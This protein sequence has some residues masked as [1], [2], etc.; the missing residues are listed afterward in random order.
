LSLVELSSS[1][2]IAAGA[3]F[4]CLETKE[5]KI[6]VSPKASLSHLAFALQNGQNRGWNLFTPPLCRSLPA[7][8]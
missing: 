2:S 3:L 4:F 5:P 1:R 6:Q 8:Q 7:L